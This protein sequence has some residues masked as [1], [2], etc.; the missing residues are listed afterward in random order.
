MQKPLVFI[1]L[2]LLLALGAYPQEPQASLDIKFHGFVR[3]DAALDNRV[4]LESREGFFVFYPLAPQLDKN[5]LDLNARANFNQWAMTSR[6][7]SEITGPELLNAKS[8]ALMEGDFTGPSNTENN[9]FRLRHAYIRLEWGTNK[10]LMGQYW[11]PIDVPEALPRILALNTGAPF[12]SFSRSPQIRF[13]Q[14]MGRFTMVGVAYSQ[15]DYVSPGPQGSSPDYV[16]YGLIPN[17]HYQLH[18]KWGKNMV[19]LGFNYKR[20]SPR[21]K[22]DSMLY[23]NEMIE[24]MAV[25]ATLKL[26]T[27]PLSIRLQGIYGQNLSDHLLLGGYAVQTEDTLSNIRTYINLNV[28]SAWIDVMSNTKV[29]QAGFFAGYSKNLGTRE[30]ASKLFY[31]RGDGIDYVY[32]VSPR[33]QYNALPLQFIAEVEYTTVAYGKHDARYKFETSSPISN[34]RWQLAAVYNF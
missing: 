5:G 15:R 16:R 34:L 32:R 31:G 3:A 17:L 14:Q 23:T 13:E 29:W 7:R 27:K 9:A 18:Y 22:T 4:N 19:M 8:F 24:S 30:S 2:L 25:L 28:A 6:I 1:A 12:H 21:L 10:I 26:E 20:L 33:L 11:T